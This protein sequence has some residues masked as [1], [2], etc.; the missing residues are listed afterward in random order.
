MHT[1]KNSIIFIIFVLITVYVKNLKLFHC[2]FHISKVFYYY[3]FP[4]FTRY[5]NGFYF[6]SRLSVLNA[7]LQCQILWIL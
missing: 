2:H 5:N 3:F 6:T 1:K 4:Y 7:F